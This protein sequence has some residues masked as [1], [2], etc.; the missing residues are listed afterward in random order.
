MSPI[1]IDDDEALADWTKKDWDVFTRNPATG[2]E[3]IIR[4]V[5]TL[6]REIRRLGMTRKQ[7]K[8]LPVY[9]LAVDRP[10]MGWLKDL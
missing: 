8:R 6:R 4:D 3:E 9:R 7:F 1:P 5:R 2:E 10:G